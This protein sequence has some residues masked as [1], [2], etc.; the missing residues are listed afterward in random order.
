M[1][2]P[3]LLIAVA[4]SLACVHAQAQPPGPT[5]EHQPSFADQ[6]VSAAVVR[7]VERFSAPAP[8]VRVAK[9]SPTA[10]LPAPALVSVAGEALASA[11][12]VA[13]AAATGGPLA[14]VFAF[15]KEN[16]TAVGG[17][18]VG[19]IGAVFAVLTFLGKRPHLKPEHAAFLARIGPPIIAKGKEFAERTATPW[20]NK[21]I[22]PI[23]EELYQELVTNGVPKPAAMSAAKALVAQAA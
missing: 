19:L 21:V 11:P 18:A 20:D 17:A 9:A 7:T 4:A 6:V 12:V 16:P 2:R 8:M 15:V 23:V 1:R 22:V 5:P 13:L 14:G 10:S 3:L